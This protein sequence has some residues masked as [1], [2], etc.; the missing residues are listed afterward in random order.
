MLANITCIFGYRHNLT[1]NRSVGTWLFV[2]TIEIYLQT[3]CTDISISARSINHHM[4]LVSDYPSAD[5]VYQGHP[6][7]DQWPVASGCTLIWIPNILQGFTQVPDF[8]SWGCCCRVAT[9]TWPCFTIDEWHHCYCHHTLHFK[10][11]IF[12]SCVFGVCSIMFHL[13]IHPT[14]TVH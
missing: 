13:L 7:L 6:D 2:F 8:W 11:D 14:S 9:C 3:S 5:D 12:P 1:T 10:T 4:L